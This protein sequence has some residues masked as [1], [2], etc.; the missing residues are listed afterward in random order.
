MISVP[1]G[2]LLGKCKCLLFWVEIP[3]PCKEN[4]LKFHGS[5]EHKNLLD[6]SLKDIFKFKI[7]TQLYPPP[8]KKL[9]TLYA[10]RKMCTLNMLND[11]ILFKWTSEGQKENLGYCI[12]RQISCS[13]ASNSRISPLLTAFLEAHQRQL[14]APS[15][16]Q[17]HLTL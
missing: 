14:H 1:I 7:Q 5:Y 8:T 15:L 3:M 6:V 13:C 9:I 17:W 10:M 2:A 11:F 12:K 16:A 4:L